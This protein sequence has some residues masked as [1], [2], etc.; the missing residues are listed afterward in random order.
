MDHQLLADIVIETADWHHYEAL[1]ARAQTCFDSLTRLS[2]KGFKPGV[3]ALLLSDDKHVQQLN[4][5]WRHKDQPTNILSFPADLAA[6]QPPEMPLFLGD[7]I[8]AYETCAREAAARPVAFLDHFSHLIIHGALHLMGYDHVQAAEA[9][10]MEALEIDV[11]AS[12]GISNP[13]ELA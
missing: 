11:L 9:Q 5:K 1:E 4:K 2:P 8:L 12:I 10:E 3:V 7:M 13:Y 6:H